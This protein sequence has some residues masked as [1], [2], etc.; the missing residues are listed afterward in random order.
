[1]QHLLRL[2]L[3]QAVIIGIL[4]AHF[5][6]NAEEERG[7]RMRGP[8]SSDVFPYDKYGPITSKDTLWNIATR[9]RPD[10]R[11]SV[12]QV[13]QALYQENPQAFVDSNINYLVEGQYLKIPSF[14]NMM[15][16]NTNSAKKKSESD[17]KAWKKAQP[18]TPKIPVFIEPSVKK[19][20]LE[21]VKTEIN[22]QL[23]K[24]D[25]Q[26]QE[27]LEH[28]QNDISDSIDGLQAIL[29]ENDDL[30]Q[31]LTS[32]NDKLGIMQDEVAKGKEI[33]LQMD[34]MIKLQQA[35][36]AKAEAR[37]KELLLERQQAA[38]AEQDIMSSLWF[39]IAMGTLPA[40]LILLLLALLFKRRKQASDEVFFNELD[41]KKQEPVA[42]KESTSEELSLDDELNLDDE[43]DLSLDGELNL[44]DELDLS[45]DDEL[46]LDD[47]LDLSLDDEL[48]LDD[49][50]S[51]DLIESDDDV[52]HLDEDDSLDDLEDILL[53]DESD[54]DI[55]DGGELDQDDLDSLLSGLD[56]EAENTE[57][58]EL[59][60]GELSQD[61]L[62][63]LLGGL[64]DFDD[65]DL[66]L[67][68]SSEEK[69]E[70]AEITDPDDIDALLDSVSDSDNEPAEVT[71]PDDIDALL[72]S[73]SDPDNE[74]A[75]VTDPDD[76]DA[77]LDSVSESVNEP[78]DVTDPDDID[79]LLDSINDTAEVTD[80]DDIDALLDSVS[81]SVNEPV[82]VTDPDDI[83][84]LL[85]SI[86]DTAEV[87]DPDDIDALLESMSGNAP[88]PQHVVKQDSSE[89]M[90]PLELDVGMDEESTIDKVTDSTLS[91]EDHKIQNEKAENEAKISA[92]TAEYVT[93]FL[94]ADFT[95]IIAKESDAELAS[96]TLISNESHELDDELDIDA[97]IADTIS[98]DEATRD[99]QEDKRDNVG[100]EL[101]DSSIDETFNTQIDGGFTEAELSQ[102]LA[103]DSMEDDTDQA[104]GISPESIVLSPDFT[105]EDVLADLL[106]E[107]AD[108]EPLEEVDELDVIDELA[109]VDFDELLANI[110][111]ESATTPTK[112]DE[113]ELIFE[114]DDIGDDL[115]DDSLGEESVQNSQ[116]T[117]P[118][119]DYVSVDELISDS[120]GEGDASEPYEKTNIDVGLGKFA[121]NDSGVDVDEDG[122]MS[123]KLDLAK[124]YIEM[125]DEE[126]AQVI[127]QEVISKGDT[128]Q[129]A[130]AQ[131]LLDSL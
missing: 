51:I 37:E 42:K 118:T 119:E 30:R 86:N 27:R 71:D 69:N 82:D 67:E 115:I 107:M 81:E 22:D 19:K 58:E 48:N 73:V 127:L 88:T 75:E 85:D 13:M 106:S 84:A 87:T 25:G 78:V 36:L 123:S 38:L 94:T 55:L 130:E 2:C 68:E 15:A 12:Y 77:L 56:D 72:D 63:D 16:I 3:W 47:E 122:S 65:E 117:E 110:E 120:L 33:K 49:D 101:T 62:N 104:E 46:N 54:V 98:K 105:D 60:G 124:M 59:E 92:F 1:M 99:F 41:S 103:D 53:D 43:L 14:N 93:P 10:N 70:P 8:K 32:F 74:T 114:G 66:V 90:N 95:D 23:Q 57:S 126:N 111:E 39:K 45:L 97:L 91:P 11:L 109:N 44:D 18:K 5:P 31:Q 20:D 7:I 50:L 131:A 4:T 28:I 6:V 76:I 112:H 113:I 24:I 83:D 116:E 35:L 89:A 52:I 79:A 80:P 9:V 34:D 29:K 26:Q 125:N 96:E 17:S 129:R 61:D 121:Q 128:T 102:L 21:T 64:D 108:E 40:I 100:D